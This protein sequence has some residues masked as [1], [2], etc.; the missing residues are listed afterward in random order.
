MKVANQVILIQHGFTM[1]NVVSKPWLLRKL[2]VFFQIY[3]FEQRNTSMTNVWA[4]RF[5]MNVFDLLMEI[6]FAVARSS[7][8]RCCVEP[9]QVLILS[10]SSLIC[11]HIQHN[12]SEIKFNYLYLIA[13]LLLQLGGS[14]PGLAHP[15]IS[16]FPS[17]MSH[18][19]L[20]LQWPHVLEQLL[21]YV[22]VSQP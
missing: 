1:K 8:L 20:F 10:T 4:L 12:K 14:Y 9:V 2:K 21:P 19:S 3:F 18:V 5:C 22:P 15:S 13:Y 16:H 11:N 6:I 7:S 17:S